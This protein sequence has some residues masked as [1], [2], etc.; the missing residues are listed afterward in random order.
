MNTDNTHS[1]TDGGTTAAGPVLDRPPAELE[2][3]YRPGDGSESLLD[4]PAF[5]WL[6]VP[7]ATAYAVQWSRNAAFA[8]IE[9]QT[10]GLDLTLYTPNRTIGSGA[11]H[12]RYG[13]VV[14]GHTWW[15]RPRSFRVSAHA[16][17]FPLPTADEFIR[18]IP[19]ERPRLFVTAADVAGLRARRNTDLKKDWEQI[20]KRCENVI[21]RPIVAEPAPFTEPWGSERNR[22]YGEVIS[23]TRGPMDAM[24]DCAL[25]YLLSGDRAYASEA[26]RRL[27]HFLAWDP[28]GTTSVFYNDEPAMWIMMRGI[29]AYDWISDTLTAEQRA[30]LEPVFRL[31][32]AQFYKLLQKI[33]FQ[34]RP[35]NSHAGRIIGF[36]GEAS[37]EFIHDWP[38]AHDWLAYIVNIY[39]GVYPAWGGAGGGWQEGP[40]Y[41]S[42][43]M[44]FGLHFAYALNKQTGVDLLEL[45]FFHATPYY[46]IYTAPPYAQTT[47]F[48]D[49][50]HGPAHKGMGHVM[51]SFSTLLRDGYARWYSEAMGNNGGSQILGIVLRDPTVK[52]LP[53]S[54]LPPAR[55]FAENGLVAMHSAL[56]DTNDV[57]L[58]FR[59]SPY[60][61]VS[62]GHADQNAFVIQ[63]FG[64]PL[65]IT[66]GYYPWWESPHHAR[67]AW[68]T[69]SV[70]SITLDGG[71]GQT[72]RSPYARGRILGFASAGRFDYACGDATEAYGAEPSAN[73]RPQ[74]N[75][76][77]KI[78]RFHRHILH[79][80]PGVF[81]LM[82]DLK[83]DQPHRYEWLLH[84]MEQ[85]EIAAADRVIRIARGDARLHVRLLAPDRLDFSQTDQSDP[86]PER[87]E[88]NLWHLKA[89]T[90]P[91]RDTRFFAVMTAYRAG[92]ESAIPQAALNGGRV[93]LRLGNDRF[94]IDFDGGRARWLDGAGQLR[95]EMAIPRRTN[96][97]ER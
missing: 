77:P 50:S 86:P 64:Q 44:S 53:P 14:D 54:G 48:G 94:E 89:A 18:R 87:G 38:E 93:T 55:L 82:D 63:G 42:A 66:S 46:A 37:M 13:A 70:N 51:Y 19:K 49:G 28:E 45:P 85:M 5:V 88:P 65:A 22:Q 32:A 3:D 56:G 25:A 17:A 59:S 74:E 15:S 1:A 35:F 40:G 72:R 83:A 96:S 92:E 57:Y 34:S 68:D 21:G 97:P 29:R 47:P 11:W 36:L 6:P 16:A 81:V 8:S 52:A 78:T 41:W 84:S 60:G 4:P 80:R 91:V 9:G 43:Y 23:A 95:Q 62:H 71:L 20:A 39:R 79:I 73:P 10:A 33:P 67:W 31:R 58:V 12:W 27:R 26:H 75:L 76:A 24:E 90:Q 69:R 30:E 61:S 2:V 7:D